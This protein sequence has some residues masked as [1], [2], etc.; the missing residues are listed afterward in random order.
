MSTEGEGALF[1]AALGLQAPWR[2]A[3]VRFDEEAK[4]LHI[5]L[6]FARGSVFACPGCGSWVK[7]YDTRERIW[8]HLNFFEHK[9]Y[10]HADFP[11]V[12][13][14]DCGVHVVDAPWARLGSGFTLLF[15]AYILK[16]CQSMPIRSVSRLVGEHDTRVWRCLMG[17]VERAREEVDMSDVTHLGVDETSWKAK[18]QYVTL[19]ADLRQRRVLFVT[20]NKD[21]NTVAEFQMELFDHQGFA[22][23][24]STVCMDLSPAY[25]LGFSQY[26]SQATQIFDRFHVMK[27]ANDAV[28]QV[29]KQEARTNQALKNTRFLWLSNPQNLTVKKQGQLASMQTMNL[30]TAKAYQMKLNLQELWTLPDRET[31]QTHLEAWYTSVI[32]SKIGQPMKKLARTVKKNAHGI[33]SFFPDRLTSGLMEGINSLIQAAKAKARGYTNLTYFKTVVYLIAGKLPLPT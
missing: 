13:C 28:D 23:Q 20:E 14:T 9:C 16:L 19:F 6:D 5:Y 2:V 22:K 33:L 29:R 25:K 10:L 1:T 31:A 27:L 17:Y 4:E 18:Y 8:R 15:E 3:S 30:A 12:E 24:I 26:F 32:H 7:A 21:A 11:R